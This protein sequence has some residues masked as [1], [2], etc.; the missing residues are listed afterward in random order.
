MTTPSQFST[1]FTEYVERIGELIALAERVADLP[2]E[3]VCSRRWLGT[4]QITGA[5]WG[6]ISRVGRPD[7]LLPRKA[8]RLCEV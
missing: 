8:Y 7:C 6:E 5:Y 4:S 2:L 3:L 1:H